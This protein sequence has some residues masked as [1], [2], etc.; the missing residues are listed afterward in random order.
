MTNINIPTT[1]IALQPIDYLPDRIRTIISFSILANH[2]NV[3]FY[4]YFPEWT[5]LFINDNLFTLIDEDTWNTMRSN[6]IRLDENYK[7][8][9]TDQV[10]TTVSL[11]D[12]YNGKY[13]AISVIT[14]KDLGKVT[15]NLAHVISDY[16]NKYNA[17]FQ[18]LVPIASLEKQIESTLASFDTVN[19]AGVYIRR[20]NL[21]TNPYKEYYLETDDTYFDNTI[22]TTISQSKTIFLVSDSQDYLNK[23][24]QEY[25]SSII[26]YM[27]NSL[28]TTLIATWILRNIPEVYVNSYTSLGRFG[29]RTINDTTATIKG[30]PYLINYLIS[31]FN[32]SSI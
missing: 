28:E 30:K 19:I 12:I 26:P 29:T 31:K 4:V 32:V 2:L 15:E 9:L 14:S 17:I 16:D 3:P 11:Y 13:D 18:Q 6:S 22:K 24:T 27:A 20:A 7:F 10:E 5:S 1:F 23:Y 21:D 8:M 25:G